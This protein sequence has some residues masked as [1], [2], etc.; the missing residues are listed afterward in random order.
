MHKIA[1][2]REDID[3]VLVYPKTGMDLGATIAPPHGLLAIA[4]PLAKKG[5][6]VKIIDQ[7][8]N[9]NWQ[10][11]LADALEC[12]PICVG[13]SAMTGTQIHFA[14]KLAQIIRKQ[15]NGRIPIV[16][17]GAHPSVMPGQ[18][19]ED[20]NVDIVCIGEGDITFSELIEAMQAKKSLSTISGIG[21]KNA[22][23][24][25]INQSRPLLDVETLLPTPWELLDIESYIHPDFYLKGSSRSLDVGQTSRGCPF[26]CGFCSSATIRRRK[27]RPMS[28]EKSLEMILGPVKKF[29]LNGI[30]IRDDEFYVNRDR[31]SS[32]CKGIVN[33]GLKFNWYSS[34]TR[35][36]TFNKQTDEEVSLILKSGAG[37]L[38]FGAESG[39]NRILKLINKGITKEDTIRA[40]FRVKKFSINPV[41]AFMIGF[42]T[43]TS[44]EMNETLDLIAKLK[45]D[46]P[47]AQI[48]TIAPYT[49]LPGT[50]MYP[51][52]LEMG[53]KPPKKLID[54]R[55]WVFDDSNTKK[56]KHPWFSHKDR[57]IIV[58]ICYI[59]MLSNAVSN[60]IGGIK[61]SYLRF[62]LGTFYKPFAAFYK[63]RLRKKF[64]KFSLDLAIIRFLRKQFF[65][66]RLLTI[67]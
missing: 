37:N 56:N 35:V 55:D 13:I 29:N 21:F 48:E 10:T 24:I 44:D 40:N 65:Y 16:W 30:W 62:V 42:P 26:Q 61:N 64:F 22:N 46:N 57:K 9:S 63:L 50:P 12:D 38:K 34:G 17:G 41:F 20:E 28:P 58:N 66:K 6:N 14:H 53:L 51:L 45:D 7:R 27:W 32:I 59:S 43:E 25:T 49:A 4:A 33:S 2:K 5:Y 8:V 67:K 31:V 60:A 15:T 1:Q 11:D 18:T 47:K 3:V 36:D 54:W 19:L 23:E 52:A 39:S